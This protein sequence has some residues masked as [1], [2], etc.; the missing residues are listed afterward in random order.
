MTEIKSIELK[1]PECLKDEE[2]KPMTKDEAREY[3]RRLWRYCPDFHEL[4]VPAFFLEENEE[5]QIERDQKPGT[6]KFMRD[7]VAF[8]ESIQHLPEEE[9]FEEIRK[10]NESIGVAPVRK[11]KHA[12]NLLK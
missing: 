1:L 5:I 11:R 10:R 4:P 12:G 9:R 6:L 3:Y 2:I 7:S 8:Y